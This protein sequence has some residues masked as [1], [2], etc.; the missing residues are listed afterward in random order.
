MK[1]ADAIKILPHSWPG[2]LHSLLVSVF[3]IVHNVVDF[4]G[5][6][7]WSSLLPDVL[8]WLLLPLAVYLLSAR[9]FRNRH[10]AGLFTL[11]TTVAYFFTVPLYTVF[12]QLPL[13]GFI[14][15]LSVL[16]PAAFLSCVVA[17]ILLRR[18]KKP[19]FPG[20]QRF[21][22]LCLLLLITY[23]LLRTAFFPSKQSTG[24]GQPTLAFSQNKLPAAAEIPDIYYFL[25]DMHP[26]TDAV[27]EVLGY[28]N[29]ALDSSLQR[30]G[31]EVVR[32]STSASNYTLPSMAAVFQASYPATASREQV[33]FREMYTARQKIIENPFIPFFRNQGY[34]IINSS[35][36]PLFKGDTSHLRHLG[37]GDPE[38]MIRN[39][40]F[41]PRL[42]SSYNWLLATYLPQLFPFREKKLFRDDLKTIDRAFEKTG[43]AIR[44][45]DT[46]KPALVYTHLLIPHE[47]FKFDSLGNRLQW[48]KDMMKGEDYN[49][50]FISQLVYCRKKILELATTILN[51]GKRHSVIIF[52]GDHGIREPEGL[53]REDLVFEVLNAMY[54]PGQQ[55]A[56]ISSGFYTPN[57]FRVIAN[58]YF[59]QTFPL[60]EK[61][62]SRLELK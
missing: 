30:L 56:T 34:K 15:K 39:Q 60:L 46:I 18:K 17:F 21:A 29:S 27:R 44:R 5:L 35:P 13:I 53:G 48:K 20:L 25:F 50:Q 45:S 9:I 14:F 31:F 2:P 23:D 28:D 16:L 8:L 22:V 42:L 57:T 47:G 11:L 4:S 1:Q 19:T 58:L 24:P 37:W 55:P 12:R 62:H 61:Q 6:V 54:L 40:T 49:P 33:S 3:F 36:F 32:N 41:V 38:E 10:N 26:S 43:E 59:G 7:S 52:Q 51:S